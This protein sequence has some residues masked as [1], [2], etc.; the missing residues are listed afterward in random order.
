MVS[1][2]YDRQSYLW[3]DL[4]PFCFGTKNRA[5]I[6]IFHGRLRWVSN[7]ENSAS[8]KRSGR[9]LCYSNA[10]F[11]TTTGLWR[12]PSAMAWTPFGMQTRKPRSARFTSGRVPSVPWNLLENPSFNCG[13]RQTGLIW[14]IKRAS[15]DDD[16]E[17]RLVA[18]CWCSS[19]SSRAAR[20]A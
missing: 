3:T 15:I 1:Q 17:H 2:R 4:L 18:A 6:P 10:I 19:S 14:L 8:K 11:R 13:P 16:D 20:T 7:R 9:I 12:G 5:D